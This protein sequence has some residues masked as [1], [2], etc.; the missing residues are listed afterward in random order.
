MQPSGLATATTGGTG[1]GTTEAGLRAKGEKGG[2]SGI[3]PGL[4]RDC[5]GGSLVAS[6]HDKIPF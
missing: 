3:S 4:M 6:T 5:H 2:H 1:G